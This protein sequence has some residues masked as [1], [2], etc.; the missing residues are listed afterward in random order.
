MIR[1]KYLFNIKKK[2]SEQILCLSH[3]SRRIRIEQETQEM[4]MLDFAEFCD[5]RI[6]FS[7]GKGTVL[8]GL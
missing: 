5:M 8:D 6:G 4:E 1:F 3:L 7:T 2:I